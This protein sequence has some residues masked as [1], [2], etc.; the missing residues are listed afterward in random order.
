MEA[1]YVKDKSFREELLPRFNANKKHEL[2]SE[3]IKLKKLH[4]K[5]SEDKKISWDLS[6]KEI[7]RLRKEGKYKEAERI[8]DTRQL[9]SDLL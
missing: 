5:I 4:R 6:T 2:T 9:L 1:K 3:E 7:N 8:E